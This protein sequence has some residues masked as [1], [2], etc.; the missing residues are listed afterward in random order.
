MT[1]WSHDPTA[2]KKSSATLPAN[3][4]ASNAPAP[5]ASKSQ[6]Q[7]YKGLHLATNYTES[8]PSRLQQQ[9]KTSVRNIFSRRQQQQKTAQQTLHCIPR[10]YQAIA[11]GTA[12]AT[13]HKIR[14]ANCIGGENGIAEKPTSAA[15]HRSNRILHRSNISY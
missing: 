15:F 4:R 8:A 5:P 10:Q 12:T 13:A 6:N 7:P 11:K 2:T 3:T 1:R 14:H 9:L